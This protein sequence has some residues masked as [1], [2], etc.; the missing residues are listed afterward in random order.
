M[1]ISVACGPIIQM[2]VTLQN[3]HIADFWSKSAE[4]LQFSIKN[5]LNVCL[6]YLKKTFSICASLSSTLPKVGGVFELYTSAKRPHSKLFWAKNG[7]C[8]Q[9][10]S[11]NFSLKYL[12]AGLNSM[13]HSCF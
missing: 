5:D 12:I 1:K 11:N 3:V 8:S 4:I 13:P 7:I 10:W 2:Y 9:F 6:C